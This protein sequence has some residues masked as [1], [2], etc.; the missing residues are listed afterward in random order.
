MTVNHT[1]KTGRRLRTTAATLVLVLLTALTTALPAAADTTVNC[2][3]TLTADVTLTSDLTCSSYGSLTV[4]ADNVTVD[5][6]GHTL[7]GAGI[8]IDGHVGLTVKNGTITGISNGLYA[9]GGASVTFSGVRLVGAKV[10]A[11]GNRT[12]VAINGT[13]RTCLVEGVSAAKYIGLTIDNCTVH[14]DVSTFDGYTPLAV[15]SSI[16]TNGSL[17]IAAANNGV[18]TGNVFDNFPV[19][20]IALSRNTLLRNN[21]FKNAGTALELDYVDRHAI[22]VEYNV[23]NGNSI[24]LGIQRFDGIDVKRNLFTGNRTAGIFMNNN[25][26]PRNPY[27]IAENVFLGN[28]RTPSG[29][30]DQEGNPVQGGIHIRSISADPSRPNLITLTRNTGAG[31]AG[32]LIWA[33]PGQVVDGGGNKGPCAPQPNPDLTCT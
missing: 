30:T 32:P 2:G 14:G 7:T 17:N 16:L 31:N 19:R 18:I 13:P 27:P 12:L 26:P 11:R 20:V 3:D 1:V 22:T 21:V 5:L 6:A 25:L 33:P 29:V 15:R 23:F 10:L 24:G 28:G 8:D 9:T 4:D